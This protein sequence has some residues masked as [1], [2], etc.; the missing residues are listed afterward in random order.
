MGY[1]YSPQM[2]L[3]SAVISSIKEVTRA[4]WGGRALAGGIAHYLILVFN[5]VLIR[6]P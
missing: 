3:L 4:E 6:L 2:A 1:D 5:S